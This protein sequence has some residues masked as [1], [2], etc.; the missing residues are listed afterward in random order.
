MTGA[1][2]VESPA[3]QLQAGVLARKSRAPIQGIYCEN[4]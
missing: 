2:A 3:T 1:E 4:V